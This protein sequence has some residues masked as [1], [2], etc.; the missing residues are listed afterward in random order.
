MD[1]N[2]QVTLP[3]DK[4]ADIA[5]GLRLLYNAPGANQEALVAFIE[6]DIKT[7]IRNAYINYM[8]NRAYD[9]DLG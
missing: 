6:E 3:D 7:R 1:V 9:L 4:L 8:R 5:A 2:F